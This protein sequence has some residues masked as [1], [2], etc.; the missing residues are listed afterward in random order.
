M[1][2]SRI[3]ASIPAVGCGGPQIPCREKAQDPQEVPSLALFA[4]SCDRA[5]GSTNHVSI[6]TLTR[7]VVGTGAGALLLPALPGVWSRRRLHPGR[8]A[9][10]QH[11]Q[12]AEQQGHRRE[13][14]A[15]SPI[16]ISS[17][18]SVSQGM[19]A[20]RRCSPTA[21]DRGRRQR[22]Q[23]SNTHLRGHRK[24]RLRFASPEWFGPC[25]ISMATASVSSGFPC[26]HDCRFLELSPCRQA[27]EWPCNP[28]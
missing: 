16:T 5:L 23:R 27:L 24:V 19:V 13:A 12:P 20:P 11:P 25:R 26:L 21:A 3:R 10:Q 1:A 28:Y 15:P 22:I 17:D 6:S 4:L 9:T 14:G 7:V 2:G 8:A 18:V